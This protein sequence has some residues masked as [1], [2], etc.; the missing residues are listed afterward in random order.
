MSLLIDWLA[1]EKSEIQKLQD[2]S[3]GALNI[4]RKTVNDLVLVN[5]D[6]EEEIQEN[7]QVIKDLSEENSQLDLI[8][9]ENTKV[10]DKIN[11]F[12]E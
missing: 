1:A 3:K 5:F 11:T 4:L 9:L 8:V 6:A 7:N 12:L 2:I 10:I